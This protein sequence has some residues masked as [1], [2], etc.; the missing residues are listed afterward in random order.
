MSDFK[1]LYPDTR[2]TTSPDAITGLLTGA[3]FNS[4]Y[5]FNENVDNV[6]I[7]YDFGEAVPVDYIF[8]G[9]ADLMARRIQDDITV[10][11]EAD[12]NNSFSSPESD[13]FDFNLTDLK[14]NDLIMPISF[15]TSYRY[16]RITFSTSDNIDWYLSKLWIGQ[17]FDFNRMPEIPIKYELK[18]E[19]QNSYYFKRKEF[20]IDLPKISAT[21]RVDFY[22]K[23]LKYKQINNFV[24]WDIEDKIFTNDK[25]LEY[26]KLID[27]N[28][29]NFS[30]DEYDLTLFFENDF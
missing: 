1:I 18:N 23:I 21:K 4:R 7:D 24:L 6:S 28:I 17:S 16:Y 11:I 13:T 25:H 3:K 19:N 2:I 30:W 27:V 12:D 8:L 9:R 15:T 22:N 14:N 20:Q 26:V 29:S 10:L 5:L